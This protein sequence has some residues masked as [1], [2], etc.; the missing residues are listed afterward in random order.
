MLGGGVHAA[1]ATL[2]SGPVGGLRV[3]PLS[4]IKV[5]LAPLEGELPIAHFNWIIWRIVVD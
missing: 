2:Q 1:N 4:V 5:G 3:L